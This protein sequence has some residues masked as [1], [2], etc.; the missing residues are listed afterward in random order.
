MRTTTKASEY[1]KKQEKVQRKF[2]ESSKLRK[3]SAEM[4]CFDVRDNVSY[5]NCKNINLQF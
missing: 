5:T 2:R 1:T 4:S 3:G